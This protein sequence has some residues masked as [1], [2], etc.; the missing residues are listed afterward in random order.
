MS[1][2]CDIFLFDCELNEPFPDITCPLPPPIPINE[3]YREVKEAQVYSFN[4][5]V[6]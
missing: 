5:E 2:F 4:K 1:M 6:K 3:H